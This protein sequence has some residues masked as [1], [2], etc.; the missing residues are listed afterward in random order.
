M[1]RK[2]WQIVES[3]NINS[4]PLELNDEKYVVLDAD[5]FDSAMDELKGISDKIKED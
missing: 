2:I 1:K 4:T 3:L 5:E